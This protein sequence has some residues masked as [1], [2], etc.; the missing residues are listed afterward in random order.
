[1]TYFVSRKFVNIWPTKFS[2]RKRTASPKPKEVHASQRAAS[3]LRERLK[4]T[5]ILADKE[6]CGWHLS[7]VDPD[8]TAD[9]CGGSQ[10]I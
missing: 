1:M 3:K 6:R 8:H 2:L 7:V 4:V 5:R 10:K 9:D